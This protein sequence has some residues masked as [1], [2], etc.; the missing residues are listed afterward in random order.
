MHKN[1]EL[2]VG[3][4]RQL[5]A[6][7]EAH[8]QTMLALS[9]FQVVYSI[10]YAGRGLHKLHYLLGYVTLGFVFPLKLCTLPFKAVFMHFF[11]WHLFQT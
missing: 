10:I 7:E 3:Q 8:N 2:E 11:L 6:G 5:R 9:N 4:R 1:S